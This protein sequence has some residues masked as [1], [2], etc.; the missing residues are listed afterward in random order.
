MAYAVPP[1]R[2]YYKL[3]A[4]FLVLAA[5]GV[6]ITERDEGTVTFETPAVEVKGFLR[7]ESSTVQSVLTILDTTLDTDGRVIGSFNGTNTYWTEVAWLL[8]RVNNLAEGVMYGYYVGQQS[9]FRGMKMDQVI[10]L[11]SSHIHVLR[12]VMA[13]S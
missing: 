6:L 4:I 8:Y 9:A 3:T 13:H 10:R 12:V 7:D 5:I 11:R 2:P 1:S